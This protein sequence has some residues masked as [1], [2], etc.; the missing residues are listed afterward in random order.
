MLFY[1]SGVMAT[2][3]LVSIHAARHVAKKLEPRLLLCAETAGK[4][5]NICKVLRAVQ[6]LQNKVTAT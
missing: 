4:R 6:S 5:S 3:A 1:I 2:V